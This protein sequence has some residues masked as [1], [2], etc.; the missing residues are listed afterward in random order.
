VRAAPTPALQRRAQRELQKKA[1]NNELD[2]F[3]AAT[4]D[5]D[6][7]HAAEVVEASETETLGALVTENLPWSGQQERAQ[8]TQPC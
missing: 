5:D 6:V 8:S 7:G 1:E 2:L 4:A 3:A